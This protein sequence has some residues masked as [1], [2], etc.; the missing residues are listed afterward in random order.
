MFAVGI[1]KH[2]N[3]LKVRILNVH[4]YLQ[5]QLFKGKQLLECGK[6]FPYILT[7]HI[8]HLYG[9]VNLRVVRMYIV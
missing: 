5:I 8:E 7:L 3:T 6:I 2:M 9:Q 1:K 4:L